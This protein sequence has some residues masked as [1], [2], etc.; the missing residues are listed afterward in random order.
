MKFP[1][2]K[3]L[4]DEI[5]ARPAAQQAAAAQNATSEQLQELVQ[6]ADAHSPV[7]CTVRNAPTNTLSV[8]VI[9]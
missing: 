2:L 5:S 9:E 1:N 6:W 4:V 3:G 8:E 7:G